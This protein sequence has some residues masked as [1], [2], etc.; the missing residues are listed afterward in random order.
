VGPVGVRLR[1]ELRARWRAWLVLAV[2]IGAFGGVVLGVAAGARRTATAY[3]RFVEASHGSD[4]LVGAFRYGADDY[5]RELEADPA[6][7]E[8]GKVVGMPIFPAGA[9]GEP[10]PLAGNVIAPVDGKVGYTID[11]PRVLAGRLPRLDAPNEALLNE[12]AATRF[13]AHI[14]SRIPAF[15]VES[16]LAGEV[17]STKPIGDIT[18]VGIGRFTSEVV[19]TEKFDVNE[20][21]QVSPANYRAYGRD[22]TLNFDGI[23]VRLSDG[24]SMEGFS[25][26]ARALAQKHAEEVGG[27][28]L[29]ADNADR[30]RHVNR[31]IR[32]QAVALAAFA[33]F[34]GLA[35]LFVL[36]QAL[37]RQLTDDATEA[38]IL[39]S[40]GMT[41]GQLVRLTLLRTVLIA[42]VAAVLSGVV[43]LALSPLF[44]IGA[45]GLAE[46]HP[47][48]DVNVAFLAVGAATIVGVLLARA[49][50]PAWRL[51]SVPAG[52]Q[53][54]AALDAGR[55]S[56]LARRVASTALPATAAA[57][58]RMALE[59][60]R[61]RSAVP[62]RAT[63]AGAIVGLA[64]VATTMVFGTNLDRLV[65]TPRLYG[66]TFDVMADGS[67]GPIDRTRVQRVV[68]N[69][70]NVTRF[71][72]GFYGEAAVAGRAVPAVGIDGP[73]RPVVVAGR[74][75]QA[76]DE[77]V[78]GT[79]TLK[80]AHLRIGQRAKVSVAG[81]PRTMQV[82]GRG[83][84]PAFGR[85]SFT[86]TGLGEGALMTGGA[87]QPPD[88]PESGLPPSGTWFN[89]YLFD[90][91]AGTTPA[92]E[93]ALINDL[94]E[95]CPPDQDCRVVG[96]EAAAAEAR[97]AEVATLGR[98]RWTPVLLAGL[99]AA[100]AAATV[101]HTL[102][103]SIRRRRRDL[104]L[105][106]TMGF[107]R[108]QVSATVAWQ[109]TTFAAVAAIVGL[110]VGL[111][112]GRA[113]WLALADQLGIVPEVSTPALALL[114]AVPATILLANLIAV[115]PGWLAGR[116]RPA[117]ALRSE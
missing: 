1:S 102:V 111:A 77:V 54:T 27:D 9:N 95:L 36:G 10:E 53:G 28:V 3:P 11:Q 12:S 74:A 14:G 40:L 44:P 100:L 52:V 101:G 47:G 55:P 97:P 76:D 33:G 29:I 35:G 108:G 110:P 92:Q 42:T 6:V 39:R 26:R 78:L 105:L 85:G 17:L 69:H 66:R 5:Y 86:Q 7:A 23:F 49:A 43:A 34:A 63:L 16:N 18:V 106:K 114:L 117:V 31:A 75:P 67:F 8:V 46:I 112:L 68:R 104:A 41:R 96:G 72:G 51:A 115:V 94:R 4:A 84:F 65:A 116:V 48:L 103:T 61:G 50:V 81:E 59:P 88:D 60:G 83:V 24:A 30:D 82:V 113:L 73:I 2:L 99:L 13:H 38:P 89:F 25:A 80:T 56:M 98:V 107:R 109:A 64:A 62:V 20:I 90:L 19:A 37:A 57:G 22:A 71:S 87:L 93:R 32:P 15:L 45:A 58:I 91:R 79:S 21:I 70:P